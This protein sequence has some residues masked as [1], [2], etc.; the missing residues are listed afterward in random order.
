MPRRAILPSRSSVFRS[1]KISRHTAACC[2]LYISSRPSPGIGSSFL[3]TIHPKARAE[4]LPQTRWGII[5]RMLRSP[6]ALALALGPFL[7]KCAQS[8]ADL[9]KGVAYCASFMLLNQSAGY[10]MR[11]VVGCI[12]AV[13]AA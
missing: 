1:G 10:L 3:D 6:F 9:E 2:Y 11:C 5:A 7:W 13:R 8:A 4:K 12:T